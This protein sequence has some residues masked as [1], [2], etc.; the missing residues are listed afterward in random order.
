VGDS[1]HGDERDDDARDDDDERG[2]WVR[3]PR[4]TYYFPMWVM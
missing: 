1:L 4:R 3:E 2:D